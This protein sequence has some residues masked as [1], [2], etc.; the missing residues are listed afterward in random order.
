M[1]FGDRFTERL[2]CRDARCLFRS[3]DGRE[4]WT[5]VSAGL[6]TIPGRLAFDAANPN[7][8]YAADGGVFVIT[9]VP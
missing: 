8:V 2:V 3:T 4:S 6:T 5:N 1:S 7:T 9:F